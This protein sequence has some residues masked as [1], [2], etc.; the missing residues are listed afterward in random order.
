MKLNAATRLLS[1]QAESKTPAMAANEIQI[2]RQKVFKA[3]LVKILKKFETQNPV[4]KVGRQPNRY[5]GG[6]EAITIRICD[7]PSLVTEFEFEDLRNKL[8]EYAQPG[9]RL[10]T[11]YYAKN[12]N[13]IHHD[14]DNYGL[15]SPRTLAEIRGLMTTFPEYAEK[16]IKRHQQGGFQYGHD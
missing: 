1:A 15:R 10:S 8:P 2:E 5:A 16:V 9:P 11:T 12:G 13:I 14:T 3:E 7:N 4:M 6:G